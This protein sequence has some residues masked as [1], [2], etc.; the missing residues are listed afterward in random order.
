MVVVYAIIFLILLH[1]FLPKPRSIEETL[2][3]IFLWVS[4]YPTFQTLRQN[5]IEITEFLFLALMLE[6]LRLRRDVLA[7]I[8]LGIASATK[9][10]PLILVFYFLWRR[11]FKL[12][13]ISIFTT[14][15]LFC[16]VVMFKGESVGI[17]FTKLWSYS[18]Q[19]FPYQFQGNQSISGL[20]SRAFSQYDLSNRLT[21][22]IPVILN[23]EAAKTATIIISTIIFLI[24]S[25]T[26]FRRTRIFP[27]PVTDIRI[28][29]VEI[30]I[31]LTGML[32]LLPHNH[33]HYFILIAWIYLAFIREWPRPESTKGRCVVFL[34]SISFLL[35]GLLTIWRLFDPFLV[36]IG[37]VTGIDLARLA[38]FPLFGA[39]SGLI[40]LLIIHGNLI[41]SNEDGFNE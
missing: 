40:A 36:L 8:W 17:A 12:A 26:I 37:P 14:V 29:S 22:E 1:R 27:L 15:F 4:F 23:I 5:N 19:P 18:V 32:I 41:S 28:E 11:R 7:G 6:A 16:I 3:A 35:L 38:S 31:V 25:I 39:I 33:T 2:A 24:V 20:F 34:T 21:I 9:I 13:I 30:A 10:L